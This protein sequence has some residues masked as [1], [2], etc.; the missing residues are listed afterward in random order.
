MQVGTSDGASGAPTFHVIRLRQGFR[1]LPEQARICSICRAR[2]HRRA[3]WCACCVSGRHPPPAL[4]SLLYSELST[5]N[6]KTH[7]RGKRPLIWCCVFAE[8]ADGRALGRF[9]PGWRHP[10]ARPR[11]RNVPSAA[12]LAPKRSALACSAGA[13]GSTT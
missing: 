5:S 4:D 8:S 11:R 7:T 13:P 2:L 9:L 6:G 10:L 3:A 12:T 1:A